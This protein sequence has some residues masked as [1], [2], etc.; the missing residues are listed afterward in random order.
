MK[1]LKRFLGAAITL[2][3][4]LPMLFG[5]S[6]ASYADGVFA[7][8]SEADI[9]S[10]LSGANSLEYSYNSAENAVMLKATGSDPY[11]VLNVSNIASLSASSNKAV[12]IIYKAMSSNSSS[13]TTGELFL[14]AGSITVPTG[15][16]SKTFSL[17]SNSAYVAKVIDLSSTSWWTG[18]I[19]CIRIDPFCSNSV[20]DIMYV[21][22]IIVAA[23]ATAANEI[24][25]E[26]IANRLND[27]KDLGDLVCNSYENEKYTSPFWKGNI[28]Y[29]EAIFPEA[30]TDGN[31][32]YT[33][34]YEPDEITAVYNATFSAKYTEGVDFT[35]EGNKI[36]FL[37][38]GSITYYDYTYI[39]PQSNPNNYGWYTYYVRH[40][41]GDGKWELNFQGCFLTD[42][43]NVTYTHSDTWDYYE[44]ESKEDLLPLTAEKLINKEAMNV[45]FFG[46]SIC[47]GANASSYRDL[48][49]YAEPW[50]GQIIGYLEESCG[51]S[52]INDHI[53]SVGGSDAGS[54]V[55]NIDQVTACD[56][57]L[58][59]IEFGVNDGMNVSSSHPSVSSVA[60]E[61]KTAIEKMIMAIRDYNED[62]EI[63]LVSPFYPNIYCHYME[64]FEAFEQSLLE[65]ES[66]YSGV[67]VANVTA[68][69]RDLLEFKNYTDFNGDNQCHPNDFAMRLY[70]QTCLATI[71]P[72]AIG[73]DAYIPEEMQVATVEAVSSTSETINETG[74]ASFTVTASGNNLT[75]KWTTED[76]VPAG[77]SVY[78]DATKALF[79]IVN[80]ALTEDFTATYVCTVTDGKGNVAVS[81]QVTLNYIAPVTVISGDADGDGILSVSDVMK[82]RKYLVRDESASD[83]VLDAVDL[84][85]DQ[86]I[87]AMDVYL[88]RKLLAE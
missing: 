27:G 12:A 13:A 35:V 42:Y 38:T 76:T 56:P 22:S 20:G 72:E 63:V 23:D 36:T 30:D 59:F 14:S 87:N 9:A 62:C 16:Y 61:Y 71:V 60:S 66:E 18:K 24:A 3:M 5:N 39:H 32:T 41:A 86:T 74:Y 88:L 19:N 79:I 75:Y 83:I 44:P 73:F 8:D 77:V 46:D 58:V 4:L 48:Y 31:L 28:V 40:A 69:M 17:T 47:G 43:I 78:G 55:E 67:A 2:A 54:M 53:I 11:V 29:N 64:Y 85:S 6:V 68:L 84:N 21:D 82:L 15:G 65:L 34:M 33:L 45:V 26:R 80:Q 81:P 70:S 49:P 7:F 37:K 50:T 25:Q 1:K 10:Y 57:D 51:N 52:K